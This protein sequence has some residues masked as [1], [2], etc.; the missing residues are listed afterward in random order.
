MIY[1]GVQGPAKAEPT[2]YQ[3]TR[4]LRVL[5]LGRI[6]RVKGQEVLLD[7]LASLPADLL[8]RFEVRIVGS[9]FESVD[10][11]RA[12]ADR[13]VVLNLSGSVSAEPFSTDPS[14]LYRW[15]DVVAVPSRRPESLGRVA[16]EAMAFGRPVLASAI[17][18]LVEVVEDGRTGWLVPPGDVA[19]LE[20]RLR[21]I[22]LNPETWADFGAAGRQRYEALFGEAAAADAIAGVAR[23]KLARSKAT[24]RPEPQA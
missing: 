4:P 2:V 18:G 10:R 11:E 1:N 17:G 22:V 6:N 13:I 21:S 23:A 24:M 20:I 14:P 5:M 15:A 12:L 19:A 8:K 16:I 3:G 7:A 9:A